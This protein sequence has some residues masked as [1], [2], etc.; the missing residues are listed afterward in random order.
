MQ[1][2]PKNSALVATSDAPL[3]S[4][5]SEAGPPLLSSSM[6]G[7]ESHLETAGTASSSSD[8]ACAVEAKRHRGKVGRSSP[9]HLCKSESGSTSSRDA[10]K[11]E[12]PW[13]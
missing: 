5:V 10:S 1:S 9:A 3:S 2:T 13:A 4:E 11:F 7:S 12:A 8:A 6:L